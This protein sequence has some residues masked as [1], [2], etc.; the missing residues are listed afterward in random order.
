MHNAAR[1]R[2]HHIL[3]I[4]RMSESFS[5]L[6]HTQYF[7]RRLGKSADVTIHILYMLACGQGLQRGWHMHA[8]MNPLPMQ[9]NYICMLFL[10]RQYFHW[11]FQNNRPWKYRFSPTLTL[12][13]LKNTSANSFKT[14]V[15]EFL[16]IIVLVWDSVAASRSHASFHQVTWKLRSSL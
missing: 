12:T 5:C 2:S 4:W 6:A 14:V 16:R 7:F 1:G 10:M 9:E 8:F 11:Q 15:I 13:A 3:Y